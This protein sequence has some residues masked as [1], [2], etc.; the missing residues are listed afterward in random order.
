[1]KAFLM[2]HSLGQ[3]YTQRRQGLEM[4]MVR[5]HYT[6]VH[7]QFSSL[8]ILKS[9]CGRE[10]MQKLVPV[11]LCDICQAGLLGREHEL[12]DHLVHGGL[13]HSAVH[14][15]TL[16]LQNPDLQEISAGRAARDQASRGVSFPR[17]LT[18][19]AENRQRL[20]GTGQAASEAMR[21][22]ERSWGGR[23][24]HS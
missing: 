3:V 16:L 17:H 18:I 2:P 10:H 12:G 1:M 13:P 8:C 6:L 20:F 14:L 7:T 24:P 23:A 11:H 19:E 4:V 21:K 22:L 15:V 9:I 5:E